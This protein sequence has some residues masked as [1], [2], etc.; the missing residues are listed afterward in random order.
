MQSEPS[1][2]IHPNGGSQLDT[3]IL[4]E[5]TEK[6]T[7]SE[8]GPGSDS[9]SESDSDSHPGSDSRSESPSEPD[10]LSGKNS[11]L[12]LQNKFPEGRKDQVAS[13]KTFLISL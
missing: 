13:K 4:T 10:V 8:E 9:G 1:A 6:G 12:H 5:E 2:V 7:S 3:S 11:F